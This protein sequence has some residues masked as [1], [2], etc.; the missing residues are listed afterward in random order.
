MKKWL[1]VLF[2]MLLVLIPSIAHAGSPTCTDVTNISTQ[3]YTADP[4]DCII[5]VNNAFSSTDMV[6]Y[7]PEDGGTFTVQNGASYDGD[8]CENYGTDE[9]PF[10][11]CE[12]QGILVLSLHS[13]Y[14]VDGSEAGVEDAG[15]Y[16]QGSPHRSSDTFTFNGDTGNWDTTYDYWYP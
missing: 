5:R 15:Q 7:L 6:I 11:V 4:S 14:T 8:D 13:G 2:L 12:P 16:L 10:I 9:D 1:F 3:S